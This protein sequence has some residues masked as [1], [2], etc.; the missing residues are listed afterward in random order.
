VGALARS[1]DDIRPVGRKGGTS[2][3]VKSSLYKLLHYFPF[4][5]SQKTC[6]EKNGVGEAQLA[7]IVEIAAP[8]RRE[9]TISWVRCKSRR[10]SLGS[11]SS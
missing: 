3:E 11:A 2:H 5:G 9:S 7:D 8:G 6:L 1:K 10:N 4:I